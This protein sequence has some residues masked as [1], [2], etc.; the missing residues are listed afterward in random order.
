[1][2]DEYRTSSTTASRGW[3]MG[4]DA[5]SKTLGGRLEATA[6]NVTAGIEAYRRYWDTTTYL[7]GMQYRP[8]ASLPGAATDVVGLFAERSFRLSGTVN[9]D[10]GLRWDHASASVDPGKASTDLT[11]AYHGTRATEQTDSLP[12]GSLRARWQ[13]AEGLEISLGAGTAARIPE[14]QERWFSLRRMGTDWVGNPDLEPSRNTALDLSASLRAGRFYLSASAFLNEIADF[15]VL[16]D[17]KKVNMVP[18][19]MNPAAR[20]YENV[21]ARLAGGEAA[22]SLTLTDRL[23]FSGSVSY[24]RGT[25]D[26]RPELGI[27]STDVAEM[28][29]V[30]GR[31]S[32]R[33]DNG[34]FWGEAEG[35]FAAAQTNVDSDLLE[36]TTPGWGIANLRAGFTFGSLG[37]TAGVEMTTG[38]LGQGVSTAVGLALAERMLAARFNR[39]GHDVVDHH[40]YVIASDGDLMEGVSHEAC[41]LAGHLGLGKLVVL[42]DDNGISIDG[43]TSLS[44]SEDVPARF[45]AYGW[46]VQRVDGHDPDAVEAA[47]AA[48]KAEGARPSLV[49]CRTHIGF[50]SPNRQDTSKAHGEPLGPDEVKLTKEKLGWPA[51]AQFLVPDEVRAFFG[52]AASRG[53]AEEE[54]ERLETAIGRATAALRERHES[55]EY[56]TEREILGTHLSIVEDPGLRTRAA[57][58]VSSGASAAA[59]ILS[60]AEHFAEVFRASGSSLLAERALDIHDVAEAVVHALAGD[61]PPEPSVALGDDSIVVAARLGPAQLLALPRA[62]VRGLVLAEGGTLSH[63]VVLARAFG[64]PCVT[65]VEGVDR[66]FATGDELIVDGE[67]GLVVAAPKEPAVRF[68]EGQAEV[69]AAAARRLEKFRAAR[70]VAADGRRIEVGANVGTVEE[71]QSAFENGAEGIGLFR[72]ELM[73]L[74][75]EE[76]PSEDEQHAILAETVRL[77]AGRPVIVRTLDVGADK[78]LA[79]M[80]VP[81][82]RNPALGYRAIRMYA[83]H[84]DLVERQLRAIL[85]DHRPE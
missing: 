10:A 45:A 5:F 49:A 41:A 67:R 9:L 4:T 37:L 76:P 81:P 43:P 3:S 63:T 68:Y 32:L 51:D 64:V 79:W 38:P 7:A 13:A 74:D 34:R 72:T 33:W 61:V 48:A 59:A 50:G 23:V 83:E 25:Q 36:E 84:A 15:V 39:D 12:G 54:L 40:T 1:M 80:R 11:W 58:A 78:P 20:T 70:G 22:A 26:P 42:Y 60:A 75:R 6:W 85:R 27:D 17:V 2:T 66:L 52:E 77:A 46:H 35:V 29:P 8:Q 65:G 55:A 53:T 56:E 19:V 30:A 44:F 18:G 31:A 57:V 14:P 16:A 69:L 62:R 28:P 71:A 73:F 24:V 47:V 21:D 82:E